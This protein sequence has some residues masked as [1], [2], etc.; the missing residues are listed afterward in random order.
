MKFNLDLMINDSNL[1]KRA[2]MR[3]ISYQFPDTA[4]GRLMCAVVNCAVTDLSDGTYR[5]SA[6]RYLNGV[7]PHAEICEV[8]SVWIHEVLTK[9]GV[10]LE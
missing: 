4:E 6:L 2:A 8:D 3:K 10:K 9:C 7:M 1:N 5:N